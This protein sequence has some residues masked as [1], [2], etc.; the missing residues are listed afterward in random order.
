MREALAHAQHDT[1]TD[2]LLSP[3]VSIPMLSDDT[4]APTPPPT[5]IT[6][7][8]TAT[9]TSGESPR[10]DP[11]RR[12]RTILRQ[13]EREVQSTTDAAVLPLVGHSVQ[14]QRPTAAE[15]ERLFAL[16]RD[17]RDLFPPY[18]A[19]IWPSGLALGA[20]ALRE[21][22][23]L[24]GQRVL[25]LGCGLGVTATAAL[26]ADADVVAVD[27]SPLGL[28]YC[29]VNALTNAGRSPSTLA[30][31]WSRPTPMAMARLQAL[32]PFGLIL[33]ADVLYESRDIV[34]LLQMVDLL[35][36]EDGEFWLAEPLRQTAGR[37]LFM[38]AD[39]GWTS[40]S[41]TMQVTVPDG[42]IAPVR[43]HR[44]Q[45]PLG[46]DPLRTTLGGWRIT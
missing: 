30:F 16:A 29:R 46:I 27:Q 44:L 19:N 10:A 7:A 22:R 38:V 42:S 17:N 41:E 6:A 34:P 28:A 21:Q 9:A 25:E 37:F 11:S 35:L 26:L 14:V 3:L 39:E 23:R 45:R 31:N 18:W 2:P 33:A 12:L 43:I 5:P 36:A 1:D 15:R 4:P 40:V 32:G 8:V 24:A 20:V 13:I